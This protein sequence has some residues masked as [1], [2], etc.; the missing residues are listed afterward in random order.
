MQRHHLVRALGVALTVLL[1]G[2]AVYDRP[3]EITAYWQ[4]VLQ[5]VMAFLAAAGLNA[6][7]KGRA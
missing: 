6:G 3:P 4:P 1:T 2:L 7:V 5:A